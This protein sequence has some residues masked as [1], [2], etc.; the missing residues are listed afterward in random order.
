MHGVNLELGDSFGAL[1]TP[2]K[3]TGNRVVI[4]LWKTFSMFDGDQDRGI[5]R[6]RIQSCKIWVPHSRISSFENV[7]LESPG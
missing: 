5:G 6:Y 3:D 7:S 2:D 1:G 4:I